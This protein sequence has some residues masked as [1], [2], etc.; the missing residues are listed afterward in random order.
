MTIIHSI[1]VATDFSPGSNAAVERAVQLAVAHGASLR[2]LHAFDVSLGHSVKGIF[3]PQRLTR[4]APPDVL[5]R[6]HLSDL[7]AALA[8]QTG[9]RVEAGFSVGK[10]DSGIKAYAGA[11]E[12]ALVVMGSRAEPAATG[13]GST[14]SKVVRSL[15]CPVL[16]VRSGGA[17]SYEKVLLAVDMHEGSARVATVALSLFPAAQH[18]LLYAVDPALERVLGTSAVEKDQMR[19][20]HESMHALAVRQLEQ[21]ARELTTRFQHQVAAEV[22]E[23]VPSRAIVERAA[24]LHADCVAVG[25]HG[26]GAG[27]ERLL[28]SMV[29]HVLHHT[30][31]DVLVV[32]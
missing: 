31:R 23:D 12:V 29:Q 19:V 27:P 4:N 5:M 9:L 3:D 2:L 25:H 13:L 21:M 8:K 24:T 30:L 10:A 18:H 26:H 20:P 17:R 7:A 32:P 1:A 14:A 11:H 28:G 15:A 16:I 6:Q 22:L